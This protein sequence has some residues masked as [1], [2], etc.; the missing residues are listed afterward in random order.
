[1]PGNFTSGAYTHAVGGNWS[2]TGTF[3]AAGSTI[4]FN[5]ANPGNIGASNFNNLTFSGAGVK[6]ATGILN[7]SGNISITNNFSAGSFGHTIGGNW[8]SSAG[9]FTPGTSLITFNGT[10][11]QTISATGNSFYDLS[12][13]NSTGL[14]ASSALTLTRF[15]TID[16]GTFATAGNLTMGEGSSII[17]KG[18]GTSTGMTGTIAGSNN[19]DVRYEGGSKNTGSE[20]SGTGLRDVN[21][22]L[23]AS[24]TLTAAGNVS[25]SGLLTIPAGI[26]LDMSTFPLTKPGLSTSGTGTLSTR[27]TS[28]NPIPAG[29]SWSFLVRYANPTGSQKVVFGTYAGLVVAGTSGTV[30]L[31]Q[32]SE[33]NITIGS[34][35]FTT[36]AGQTYTVTGST[37][38]FNAA[39]AQTLPGITFNNVSLAGSGDKTLSTNSQ[40][41][42]IFSISGTAV[43]K[44]GNTNRSVGS[45]L[46]NNVIQST[47]SYGSTAS[48]ATN[49]ISQFFGTT[50]TG[51][52][53]VTSLCIDGEWLGTTSSNW[54]E[55]T[56]WCGGVPTNT[57]DVTIPATAPNQPSIGANG[58]VT[59]SIQI[60]TGAT[61]TVSG[62]FTLTVNG[63][64]TNAGTF[65]AGTS[66]VNFAGSTD[67]LIGASNFRN[68][69]LS[70]TGV[71]SLTGATIITGNLSISSGA[72]LEGGT[73]THSL[74]GNFANA[75]SFLAE[76]STFLFNAGPST[77]SGAAAKNF[78]NIQVTNGATLTVTNATEVSNSLFL[79]SGTVAAGSNLTMAANSRIQRAGTA[80]LPTT[81]TGTLQGANAYDVTYS[82]EN[83]TAGS[84]LSGTGLR[85]ITLSLSSGNIITAASTITHTGVLTIPTGNTLAMSSFALANPNL[86]TSGT[87]TLTTQST[88]T[89][90]LPAGKT[91]SFLVNYSRTAG[92]QKIVWGSYNGL[93]ASNTSGTNTLAPLTDGGE[94]TIASGNFSAAGTYTSTG[95]TVRFSA[96]GAQS[97]P[98]I[99]YNNLILDG[100][101]DKTFAATSST[102]GSLTIAS[103]V[104]ARLLNV[105]HTANSLILGTTGQPNG[106]FGSSVSGAAFKISSSFGATDTGI[107]TVASSNCTTGLWLGYVSTDWNDAGN[108]CGAVPTA[109]TD[110]IISSSAP[111]QPIIGS[112]GAIA[113]NITIQ[114]GATLAFSGAFDLQVFG[115]WINNGTFTPSQGRVTF[116]GTGNQSFGGSSNTSIYRLIL[117]KAS[118]DQ[119]ILNSNLTLTNSL[120]L[121]SGTLTA[122]TRLSVVANTQITRGGTTGAS[123]AF[124]GTIQGAT[125]YDVTY[126][127]NSKN[128]GAELTGTGLRNITLNVVSA[129]E[130]TATSNITHSAQLAIPAGMSLNMSTYALNN[131]TTSSGTGTLKTASTVNP[132]IPRGR[133]WSFAVNYTAPTG[134]QRVSYGI[135]NSLSIGNTSGTT[136]L[137]P[138]SAGG[139]IEISSGNLTKAS[140]TVSGSGSTVN[141]SASATQAIP[142]I[143]YGD[144]I[145]QGSGDKTF[146]GATTISGTL[147]IDGT[148]IAK[149]GSS[150][151]HTAA[152]L[153]LGTAGQPNG[154]FGSSASGATFKVPQYFG[155]TG[156][157]ILNVTTSTCTPGIWLGYVSSNYN[158]GQNWC[159]GSVPNATTDVV[160]PA[161]TPFSPVI[162]T[163]SNYNVQSMTIESGATLAIQ[164]TQ[165]ITIG[166]DWTNDGTFLPGTA[167]TVIFNNSDEDQLIS[168]SGA[169]NFYS[170]RVDKA[171]STLSIDDPSTIAGKLSL[172]DGPLDSNGNITLGA[173]SSIERTDGTFAGTIQ[174]NNTYDLTYLGGN[175]TTGGETSG[176]GLR[177]MTL[178]L[179]TTNVLT[180]GAV[181]SMSGQL[182]IPATQTL[183]MGNN[184]LSGNLTTSGT[185]LLTTTN[186]SA[187][188]LPGARTWTFAVSY[189]RASG[190]QKVVYGVYHELTI[191]NTSGTTTFAPQTEGTVEIASGNLT[192]ASGGTQNASAAKLRF[193]SPSAQ[194]IPALT[195]RNLELLGGGDKIFAGVIAVSEDLSIGGSAVAKLLNVNHTANTVTLGGA[196]QPA[197]T[198]GST[199]SAAQYKISH[200]F[201]TTGTG[202]LTV[203]TGTC[204]PGTWFGVT[205]TDWN[206]GTNWCGGIPSLTTDVIIP[207]GTPFSPVIGIAGGLS[208]NLTIQSGA[209]L[210]ISD[211]YLLQVTGNWNNSGT[212]N[213]GANS[214]V[215]FNGATSG[216]ISAGNFA[217]LSFTGSGTKTIN[218]TLSVTGNISPISSPV[219]L[220]NPFSLTLPAT[221]TME[222]LASGSF[223]TTGASSK[224]IL[225]AGAIYV[226]RSSSNP[227]LESR[228]TFTGTKGWR[229]VGVPIGST[230]ATMTA[231]FETQGFPG[232]TNPSLQPNLLWW[233]ETDKGT[234]LQ[235]YRQPSGISD[236]VPAG[237]GHYFYIFDG[238][239]KPSPA[240]GNYT[241]ALPITM[242]I[243]GSE[244]NLASGIFDFQVTFTPRD[245]NLLAQSDTLIEVNQADEGFN[246]I[247][248]PTASTL[249][250][251]AVS[252]WTKT[253]LDQSIYVWDPASEAFLVWNGSVGNLGNGFIAPYQGFW[254]HANA[255][256]PS[257]TLGNE[258]KILSSSSFFGRKLETPTPTIHLR[259]AGENLSAESFISFGED[260]KAET[261]P[262]D[263]FQL[264]SL[265]EDWLLLYTF[266]SLKTQTPLVINHQAP[267]DE[268]EK[269]IPLHLAASKN[270]AAVNGSYLLDWTLPA[271][272]PSNVTVILMDHIS[273]KAINMREESAHTFSFEAPKQP[274]ARS[275]KFQN[276]L[277][278]PKAIL[279]ESPYAI[280]A[281]NPTARTVANKPQRP[282][283]LFISSK[284]GDEIGYL[285][286]L[287]KLFSP[288]PNP[289]QSAT[290][291]RFYL[292][293]TQQAEVQILDMFGQV[294]GSFPG[295][296]YKAGISEVEWIPAA[297]DLP[298]GMYIIRLSTKE[299]QVSQKL[300]KN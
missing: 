89:T 61:L 167:S 74:A 29:L 286:D 295:K 124:T 44:L 164:G 127:G 297:I 133:T 197:G 31:A 11:A 217:N 285:P 300:I 64:W 18:T 271:D 81:F 90:P 175:K 67:A 163:G 269:V 2:K 10:T 103:G 266:G 268:Q 180:A 83:K 96:A 198:Y 43:A 115:N 247:A 156:T 255:A 72:T 9:S 172:L 287:P 120:L 75:G 123:T 116:K 33:G 239:S 30:T 114:A 159:G 200:Y 254:V 213:P 173:N 111:N 219:I 73:F 12:L 165:T 231:G 139:E 184:A 140:G 118:D 211:A 152:S 130:I 26:T 62:A 261:D 179:G 194:T 121:T 174:G 94:I 251:D 20:I 52:I 208:R 108:W 102:S 230:Y 34:G 54:F 79:T 228:Q 148:A 240:T 188:P 119:V 151:T 242:S 201:G 281:V 270:G 294:V 76:S 226:N 207:S 274:N 289:F 137:D 122:S 262:K 16:A 248:N 84:E 39:A 146:S 299:Y 161:G 106:T 22:A 42:G 183:Q 41:Q 136:T 216:T 257:L 46:L 190:G 109:T 229:A 56:N 293:E 58:A 250:W 19:Y 277:D 53:N 63:N 50:G 291:I 267:L 178:A 129:N 104:I 220:N 37:V 169:N 160:I 224:I 60:Q 162:S 1:I 283:T 292:P 189:L 215:D 40:I 195:Y 275:G 132:A 210:S 225:P 245:T 68:I 203:A 235:G 48:A 125:A 126:T 70:G 23:N 157:G 192:L 236:A 272:L 170:I 134:N 69:I 47:G 141:F 107:L 97:V 181:I 38:V 49:Q 193:S 252:G 232:S 186:S 145:L 99:T 249:D 166:G 243:T 8:T 110:V 280:G 93:T 237:R 218:A 221:K 65:N 276:P 209:T 55:P 5:G 260:G 205:S 177:N 171:N 155:A 182:T 80:L 105:N 202:I 278:L 17:R 191:G 7:A 264:E 98:G 176:A 296:I 57:T 273:Q 86:T 3:N 4:N 241:D 199:A 187:S 234:T 113:R 149:L 154:S 131:T 142:V 6:T 150:V 196:N 128:T 256:S 298:A 92:G 279:F 66:T 144:L 101:G 290:K 238:A 258:A 138:F 100:S 112:A 36:T 284:T 28:L 71:K 95:S 24:S 32:A 21:L 288:V 253:N 13:N 135:Y 51:V 223:T 222:I 78:Y 91:W 265:A 88:S 158:S 282:F 185:G 59:R 25:L 263:A 117:E 87:G 147:T 143:T 204:V 35:N 85:N 212:F 259:I 168:G 27:N 82:G 15:L 153:I 227:R 206:D 77:I 45:L 244:A 214:T 233:D 246:L 14:S